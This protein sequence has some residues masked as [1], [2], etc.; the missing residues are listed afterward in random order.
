LFSWNTTTMAIPI[1]AACRTATPSDALP[2]P[3]PLKNG[4]TPTMSE[5]T[6]TAR[7]TPNGSR[8]SAALCRWARDEASALS[9]PVAYCWALAAREVTVLTA[10]REVLIE[11]SSRWLASSRVPRSISG[12]S[13]SMTVLR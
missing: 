8:L 10:S 9:W 5:V 7:S 6:I 2:E 3:M 11:V 12:Q 4:K 13:W 1:S